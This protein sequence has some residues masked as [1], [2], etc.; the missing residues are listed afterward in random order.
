[1]ASTELQKRIVSAVIEAKTSKAGNS[2][3]VLVLSFA[4]EDGR[5]YSMQV[6]LKEEQ[7]YILEGLK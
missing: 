3:N 6:F 4:G 2:Y 7:A 1:M 5:T